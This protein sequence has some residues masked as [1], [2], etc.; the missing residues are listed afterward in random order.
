MADT[1][2]IQGYDINDDE[3][4][5]QY[6]ALLTRL[7]TAETSLNNSKNEYINIYNQMQSGGS[8][9]TNYDKMTTANNNASGSYATTDSVD[10]TYQYAVS[11][12]NQDDGDE[13]YQVAIIVATTVSRNSTL[14]LN[15][16]L[17]WYRD[18]I[19]KHGIGSVWLW[20]PSGYWYRPHQY[21]MTASNSINL[22]FVLDNMYIDTIGSNNHVYYGFISLRS[23]SLTTY[24]CTVQTCNQGEMTFTAT[25]NR[26]RLINW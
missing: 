18:H 2:K 9:Q 16:P 25:S 21:T 8:A 12:L 11:S 3:L 22:S 10:S 4:R 19:C 5:A 13:E 6:Q 15:H 23:T 1:N 26:S 17:A 7:N 24:S 14:S 20:G